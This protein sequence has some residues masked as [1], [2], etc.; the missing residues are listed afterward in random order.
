MDKLFGNNNYLKVISIIIALILWMYVMA[1]QNPEVTHVY[2]DVPV[3]YENLDENK[4]AL[5]DANQ[6]LTVDVTVK[7]R[8]SIIADLSKDD[9]GCVLNLKGRMEGENLIPVTVKLPQE[10]QLVE[11]SPRE[12]AVYLD[13]VIEEQFPVQVQLQGKTHPDF[14][15]LTPTVNPNE[16]VIKGARSLVN[17]IETAAV[18]VDVEGRSHDVK[19]SYPIRVFDKQGNVIEGKLSF[20]PDTLE[21]T[22][23]IVYKRELPVKPNIIGSPAPGHLLMGVETLPET[24][25]VIGDREVLDQTAAVT[26]VPINLAGA[27]DDIEVEMPVVLPQGLKFPYSESRKVKVLINIEKEVIKTITSYKNIELH[28]IGEG[29]EAEV[30]HSETTLT[31]KGPEKRLEQLTAQDFR[32]YVDLQDLQA[33]EHQVPL[34]VELAEGLTLTQIRPQRVK[35]VINQINQTE[36]T[37]E[38]N[39]IEQHR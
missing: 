31:I 26:T 18:Q 13:A 6:E 28:N 4:L 27:A 15:A 29:L 24:V 23:P 10:V 11:V 5:R 33:G 14:I 30:A 19:G 17:S 36:E 2:R 20:R 25:E 16:V 35:V 7:A 12:L 1:E 8:R 34:K 37:N 9:I 39:Q 32:L 21:V 38:I 3:T 22:V